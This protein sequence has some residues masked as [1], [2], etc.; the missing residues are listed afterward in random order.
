M[1][2]TIKMSKSN[3]RQKLSW[4]GMFYSL[5]RIDLLIVS[6][7]GFGIYICLETIK[8]LS[9]KNQDTGLLIKISAGC[10]LA[11][12]IINFL[13]QI[14]G[15][16]SNEQDFLMCD[17][18]IDAGENPDKNEQKEIDKYDKKSEKF[19][20]WTSKLNYFS[21][22]FMFAALILMMYYFLFTF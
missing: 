18:E 3:E 6:I 22:G 11:G 1:K 21:M 14:S 8:F 7:C 20:N 9:E 16:K 4:E 17:A 2:N 10:F 15:Y 12:I 13:S 19:S 5:Q